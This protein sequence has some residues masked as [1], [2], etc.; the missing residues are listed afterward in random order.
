MKVD[1]RMDFNATMEKGDK[2]PQPDGVDPGPLLTKHPRYIISHITNK[3]TK[4]QSIEEDNRLDVTSVMDVYSGPQTMCTG[5]LYT[6]HICHQCKLIQ[7]Q[8]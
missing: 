7:N 2:G 5:A 4:H 3:V 6:N 8:I 1:D